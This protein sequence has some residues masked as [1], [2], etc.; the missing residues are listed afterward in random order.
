MTSLSVRLNLPADPR[1]SSLRVEADATFAVGSGV[2]AAYV[3]SFDDDVMPLDVVLESNDE[4]LLSPSGRSFVTTPLTA[5]SS[6]ASS[7]YCGWKKPGR[8]AG[9]QSGR[10][11]RKNQASIS[12]ETEHE[13]H[14]KNAIRVLAGRVVRIET[15]LHEQYTTCMGART[16]FVIS[17]HQERTTQK[18]FGTALPTIRRKTIPAARSTVSPAADSAR[19]TTGTRS[20]AH[21]HQ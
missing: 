12:G 11:V 1:R 10:C 21:A 18:P 8:H 16:S 3:P 20:C 13:N 5:G 4:A 7:S 15:S 2:G 6:S 9:A 14:N 17:V 19:R